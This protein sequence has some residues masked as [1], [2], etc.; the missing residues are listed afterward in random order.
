MTSKWRASSAHQSSGSR[1]W[2]KHTRG[3]NHDQ[4]GVAG[5]DLHRHAEEHPEGSPTIQRRKFSK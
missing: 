3:P 2:P 5:G 4:F 1:M